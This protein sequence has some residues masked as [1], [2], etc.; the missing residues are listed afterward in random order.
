[1]AWSAVLESKACALADRQ[2]GVV[3]RAQLFELGISRRTLARR[4]KA[5]V[6]R[7]LYPGVVRLLDAKHSAWRQQLMAVLLWLGE[8]AAVSHHA[9]ARLW[10]LDGEEDEPIEVSTTRPRNGKPP[11][12]ITIHRVRELGSGEVTV[13][14]G[15][16][17]TLPA[18]TLADLAATVSADRLDSL[19]DS[20]VRAKRTTQKALNTFIAYTRTRFI[21]ISKFRAVLDARGDGG[22]KDS[23]AER[24]FTKNVVEPFGLPKPEHNYKVRDAEGNVV[25]KADFAYPK[26]RLVIEVYSR[27]HH[28][29]DETVIHDTQRMNDIAR[30]SHQSLIFWWDDITQTPADTAAL[31]FETIARREQELGVT[32]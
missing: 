4:L 15:L 17:I 3:T 16:R 20:V 24:L 13:K 14:D 27:K 32:L 26:L 1:M 23:E 7:T 8:D 10:A 30:C 28:T 21:G 6:W 5:K 19:I 25:A 22:A 29:G 2:Y 31:L 11:V 18:R 12:G 9:A